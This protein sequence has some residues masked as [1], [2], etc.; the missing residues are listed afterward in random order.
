MSVD[1]RNKDEVAWWYFQQAAPRFIGDRSGEW[2]QTVAEHSY[3]VAQAFEDARQ[4]LLGPLPRG[5][6]SAYIEDLRLR[7]ASNVRHYRQAAGW[8]QAEL[9]DKIGM[10]EST[11]AQMENPGEKT[12]A[13]LTTVASIA[14]ALHIPFGYLFE[15][16]KTPP[17][18]KTN[19]S[20]EKL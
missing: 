18:R 6:R 15:E 8:S 5:S 9:A 14:F 20:H 3:Q 2:M 12:T 7:I 19:L 1:F 4:K 17:A 13:P 16:R 11:V 10:S